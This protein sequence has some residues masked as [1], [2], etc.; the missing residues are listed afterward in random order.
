MQLT[1]AHRFVFF[2]GFLFPSI[3]NQSVSLSAHVSNKILHLESLFARAPLSHTPASPSP[4]SPRACHQG[5][6]KPRDAACASQP[7]RWREVCESAGVR[8][9]KALAQ[10]LPIDRNFAI[11]R[12]FEFWPIG[13][14]KCSRGVPYRSLLMGPKSNLAFLCLARLGRSARYTV[15]ISALILFIMI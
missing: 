2:T 6:C 13:D 12:K 7:V 11:R 5:A 9:V 10:P 4:L 8:D 1:S 14:A 15:A 3:R